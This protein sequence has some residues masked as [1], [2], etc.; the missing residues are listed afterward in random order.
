MRNA[1]TEAEPKFEKPKQLKYKGE[2]IRLGHHACGASVCRLGEVTDDGPN[3]LVGDE[4]G[5]IYLFERK[6]LTW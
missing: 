4:R 1:G 6:Y 5:H 3:I 2:F